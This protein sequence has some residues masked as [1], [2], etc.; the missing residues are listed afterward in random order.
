MLLQTTKHK[1]LLHCYYEIEGIVRSIMEKYKFDISGRERLGGARD[2]YFNTQ[3]TLF[4]SV[5]V[6]YHIPPTDFIVPCC[7]RLLQPSQ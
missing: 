3:G 7:Y 4:H 6:S 2:R 5:P 1:L